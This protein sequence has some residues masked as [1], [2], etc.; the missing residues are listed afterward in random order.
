MCF[1]EG[2]EFLLDLPMPYV[3]LTTQYDR[4]SQQQLS[5]LFLFLQS[6]VGNAVTCRKVQA[7][8][9][10]KI[11]ELMCKFADSVVPEY[12][13]VLH[14]LVMVEGLETPLR[15]N[16]SLVMKYVM[17]SFTLIAADFSRDRDHR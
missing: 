11:T 1:T 8:H 14:A 4:L 9:V 13:D 16:Q 17:R 6:F 3:V 15:R 10:G 12:L 7:R 2:I 5:L